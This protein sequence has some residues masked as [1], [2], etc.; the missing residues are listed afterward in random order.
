MTIQA[1]GHDDTDAE[2]AELEQTEVDGPELFFGIVAA[3]GTDLEFVEK[4]IR[5]ALVE[6]GYQRTTI[7]LSELLD[8][9]QRPAPLR[10][11]PL[12]VRYLDYMDAG[13]DLRERTDQNDAL[14]ILGIRQVREVRRSA[15]GDPD[16]PLRRHAYIFRSL[17][18]P[19]EVETLRSVY[20]GGF[21]LIAAYSPEEDREEVLARRIASSYDRKLNDAHRKKAREIIIRDEKDQSRKWG[22]NVRGTF[23]LADLF[24]DVRSSSAFDSVLASVERFTK[25]I[26]GYQ[27]STPTRA[28]SAMFHA[29]AASLRSAEMG[30]Q[31]GAAITNPSGDLLVV[32]ANE[33]P[34][35]GGGL[36]WGEDDPDDRDWRRGFDANDR[37]KRDNLREVLSILQEKKWL[38][39]AR[40]LEDIEDLLLAS[41]PIM[42]GTRSMNAIEFGR[43]VHAE[44]A[45]ITDAARRGV[46]LAGTVLYTTTF[47]CHNCARH[48]IATGIRRVV[49]I[50]PYPKSLA[51]ELHSE[52]LSLEPPPADGEEWREELQ[53]LA[54]GADPRVKCSPF[55]GVSP[56]L[57]IQLFSMTRRKDDSGN[58]LDFDPSVALPRPGL[59][60][61]YL[62]Y[63]ELETVRAH[64]LQSKLIELEDGNP[65]D[66][67][68]LGEA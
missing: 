38:A 10:R 33:L 47:P 67:S 36:Y 22:Q 3:V 32:G 25:L 17:K 15:T 61:P 28:E 44:M 45:A 19:E 39:D 65:L 37:K 24:I 68:N 14:A 48:I 46:N 63:S 7:R 57:Y 53:P 30:R 9:I 43:A 2:P 51:L 49:Y 58:S 20:G 50:E 64:R 66:N 11:K 62:R 31:V 56:R 5:A 23:P 26:L 55:V 13:D 60:P 29:W 16:N 54:A 27:Y 34:K 1:A 59:A 12:D 42:S 35:A 18:T 40:N 8:E 21:F 52:S 41:L 6:A 4:A